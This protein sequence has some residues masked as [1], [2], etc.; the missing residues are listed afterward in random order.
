MGNSNL[1]D[2]VDAA[3]AN[4]QK[5]KEQDLGGAGFWIPDL[6]PAKRTQLQ[7]DVLYFLRPLLKLTREILS[8]DK[9]NE[10]YRKIPVH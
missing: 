2:P 6:Q 7:W 5:K 10:R 8:D 9:K 1:T 4:S 3:I